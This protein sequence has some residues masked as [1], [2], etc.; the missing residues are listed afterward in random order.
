MHSTITPEVLQ[1]QIN[2]E[3]FNGGL[4]A[5]WL[6]IF[7]TPK[8]KPRER[9]PLKV[10]EYHKIIKS[11]IDFILNI[12]KENTVFMLSDEALKYYNDV[13]EPTFQSEK[14]SNT[15]AFCGRYEGYVAS[16]ADLYYLSEALGNVWGK[17]EGYPNIKELRTLA[18][19]VKT[20]E[21]ITDRA[22]YS[23]DS[24]GVL[25]TQKRHVQ[26]A[27]EFVAPC[28]HNLFS[29]FFLIISSRLFMVFSLY[30]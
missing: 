22:R 24:Y 12:N 8:T 2:S 28:M 11:Q 9:L 6:V 16:I 17:Y 7:D 3:M 18:D 20:D 27:F 15:R 10:L 25:N 1:E 5:R 29:L 13:V 30:P 14:Y 4:M 19:Y 21:K 26:K 23:P